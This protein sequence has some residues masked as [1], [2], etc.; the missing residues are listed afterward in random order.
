MLFDNPYLTI[1]HHLSKIYSINTINQ[2][3]HA[4]CN[5]LDVKHFHKFKTLLT[6]L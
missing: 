2:I 5:F 4:Y 3:N 1:K 6:A